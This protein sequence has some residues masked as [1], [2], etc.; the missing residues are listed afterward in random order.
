MLFSEEYRQQ[1]NIQPYKTCFYVAELSEVLQ[2]T[3]CTVE[4]ESDVYYLPLAKM[5]K[6]KPFK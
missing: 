2:L 5:Y 1:N 4:T 6:G 3:F